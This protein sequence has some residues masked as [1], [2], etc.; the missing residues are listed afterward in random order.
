[1]EGS[2]LP[3]TWLGLRLGLVQVSIELGQL[4]EEVNR[5]EKGGTGMCKGPMA[6]G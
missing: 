3:G 5:L 2:R 4:P 6:E 1:M